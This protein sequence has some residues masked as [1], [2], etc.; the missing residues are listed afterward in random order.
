MKII[1]VNSVPYGSTGGIARNL[2]DISKEKFTTYFAYSWTKSKR[3][4][5]SDDEILI[6][7]LFGKASHM[8]LSKITGNEFYFSVIDTLIFIKKLKKI[9]PDIIHIHNIH[10]WYLNI[11]IFFTYLKKNNIRVIWTLHDCWAVTGHCTSLIYCDKWKKSCFNCNKYKNYPQSIFDN[12][13]K[14]H[15]LKKYW[16]S[17]LDDLTIVTPSNWLMNITKQTFLKKYS[18]FTIYNG[19]DLNI[20]NMKNRKE[21]FL[22]SKKIKKFIILGVSLYWTKEKGIDVFIRLAHDLGDDFQIV[23]VGTTEDDDKILP[24]NIIS[25]HKTSSKSELADIYYSADLFVNPTLG[26]VFG[27][28]NVESL[29]CGTPVLS[30]ATGGIPE[31]ICNDVGCIVEYNNYEQLKNKIIEIENGKIKFKKDKCI[32]RAEDFNYLNTYKKYL[33]LYNEISKK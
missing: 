26:D 33:E 10:N 17:Y 12:S 19:I 21:M 8:I 13:K 7:T 16:F 29:A 6:G 20:F 1:E 22:E 11:P 14:M 31:I 18:I 2:C 24:S 28:V 4:N 9:K 15:K 5:L 25:I 23:L 30:Y 3:K 32:K 27:L